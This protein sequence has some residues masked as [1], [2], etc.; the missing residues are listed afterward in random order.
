MYHGMARANLNKSEWLMIITTKVSKYM[1]Q[2]LHQLKFPLSD[3]TLLKSTPKCKC[4]EV[5]F[6]LQ[7]T[8][9]L[10]QILGLSLSKGVTF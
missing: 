10:M 7:E 1:P 3:P 9:Q 8:V 6:T 4:C 5:R 2:N